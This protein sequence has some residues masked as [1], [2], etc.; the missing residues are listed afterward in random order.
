MLADFIR[1]DAEHILQ[2]W[3]AF[4]RSM[5]GSEHLSKSHLR[6]HGPALLKAIAAD[7][8]LDQGEV[9]Q[10]EK[11]RGHGIPGPLDHIAEVHSMMRFEQGFEFGQLMSEYRAL[12]ATIFR[13]WEQHQG[14]PSQDSVD[15]IRLNE[16]IDQVLAEAVNKHIKITSEYRDRFT[17]MLGHDLRTP[18]AAITLSVELLMRSGRL[19]QKYVKVLARILTSTQ[20]LQRL[21]SAFLDLSRARF[22]PGIRVSPT[23]VNLGD[24]CLEALMEVEAFRPNTSLTFGQS[25]DL[26]GT[27]DR[28]RLVQAIF[29]LVTNAM[30]HGG[31]QSPISVHALSTGA[32]VEVSVHNDGSPITDR[33]IRRIFNQFVCD[34]GTDLR[35]FN[36]G[37]GL[38]LYLVNAI[39]RGH[40]GEVSVVSAL[41]EG[42]TF[43]VRLPRHASGSKVSNEQAAPAATAH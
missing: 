4:A 42:T 16:A 18:I 29:N 27:W 36:G 32:S 9:A 7:M 13:L 12:R 22:G 19:G 21:T 38:G 10:A 8:S 26:H 34:A 40:G 24:V 1:D 17:S 31:S 33:V 3:D 11:S 20:R 30:K 37:V 6:S 2:E 35:K 41:G 5:P 25:G 39:V 28:I 15:I 23:P 14:S 43:T